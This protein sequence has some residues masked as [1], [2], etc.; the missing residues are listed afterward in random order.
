MMRYAAVSDPIG[1][2]NAGN[3][4][5]MPGTPV[6]TKTIIDGVKSGKIKMAQL[7]ANV[8]R[9]LELVMRSPEFKKYKYSNTPN[10]KKDAQV[11]RMAAA[12][13]MIL[14]KDE[15]KALPLQGKKVALFGNTSYDLVAGGTG[16]GN[17]NKKY[18]ISLVQGLTNGGYTVDNNLKSAYESYIND[19]KSKQPKSAMSFFMLPP[20]IPQMGIAQDKLSQEANDADEAIVTIGRNAGEGAEIGR[21]HV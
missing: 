6:Q 18:T 13:G 8:E 11:S 7:N 5:L 16:S 3:D 17:V 15:G 9:V 20:P 4:L 21:A 1:Q 19:A 14:L 10:L 2:M 12:Q